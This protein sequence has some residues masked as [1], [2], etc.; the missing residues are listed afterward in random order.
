MLFPFYFISF[1]TRMAFTMAIRAT[2]TSAKTASH[3]V[4]S[5]PAPKASTNSLT[6]KA[7]EMFCH[8]IRRVCLPAQMAVATFEGWSVCITTS[9]V[10]MAASL[11]SPPIA[12]PTWLR[13]RTGASLMPSPTKAIRLAVFRFSSSM[14]ST[15]PSGSRSPYARA[16]P[17][18]SAKLVTIACL[19]PDN[20]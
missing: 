8:T 10:S 9:A 16:T 19:S 12:I 4:A 11:P 20:I 5:P 3:R 17:N 1:C 13:A 2:P 6:P 18:F 14:C 15:L 7:S